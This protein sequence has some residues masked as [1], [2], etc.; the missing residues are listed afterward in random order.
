MTPCRPS[1]PESPWSETP[2]S[3]RRF[4]ACGGW[5]VGAPLRPGTDGRAGAPR[6]TP[7]TVGACGSSSTTWP[8]RTTRP[9]TSRFCAASGST[10][11]GD[12]ELGAPLERLPPSWRPAVAPTLRGTVDVRGA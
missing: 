1:F 6:G 3:E 9:G 2:P 5:S 8:A 4:R 11:A 12:G 7:S 10:G